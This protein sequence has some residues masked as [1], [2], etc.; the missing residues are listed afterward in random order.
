MSTMKKI[1]IR[2]DESDCHWTEEIQACELASWY[3]KPCPV[4]AVGEIINQKDLDYFN[5][6]KAIT[7]I[8]DTID[9]NEEMPGVDFINTGTTR[10][11][12]SMKV[13]S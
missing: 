11:R 9:S 8:Q 1:T 6:L 13:Y 5:M 4:C 2:C 3:K 12:D 10:Y 7:D